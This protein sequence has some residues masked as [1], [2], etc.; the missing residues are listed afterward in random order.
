MLIILEGPDCAGKSTLAQRTVTQLTVRYPNARI[1]LLHRGPPKEHPLDEYVTPLLDYRPGREHHI[2]CDRWHLGELVYPRLTGRP[3][4]MDD[5]VAAYVDVFLRSRGAAVFVLNPTVASLETRYDERGDA[6]ATRP[7]LARQSYWFTLIGRRYGAEVDYHLSPDDV[8]SRARGVNDRASKPHHHELLDVDYPPLWTTYVGDRWPRVLFVGDVRACDGA[9]CR[10]N[11]V[12][13]PLGPAFMPYPGTS[14][15]YLMNTLFSQMRTYYSRDRIA[16]V[17]ACDVDPVDDVWRGTGGPVAVTLGVNA[18][19]RL[20][21]LKIPH[22]AVPHPQF[23]RRFHHGSVDA[24]AELIRDV[25][26]T[27]RNELKWRP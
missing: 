12:H 17:N 9:R 10:H 27:E 18:H 25:I 7:D 24:Y 16:F 14:G 20:S 1:Q 13:S 23:V 26:G 15:H 6:V 3:T 11:V 19:Q 22:A 5:A 2:V 21:T 4:K 8:I